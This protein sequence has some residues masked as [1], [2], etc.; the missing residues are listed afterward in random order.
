MYYID[1]LISEKSATQNTLESYRSNLHQFE[2]FLLKNGTTL[3]DASKVNIKDYVKFLYTQK[4]YKSSFIP[5]KISAAM[6]NFY[7][8]LFNDGIIDFN[9]APA[10]DDELKNPKISRPLPKYLSVNEILF[11]TETANINK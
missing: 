4:K 6:K 10:N 9:P 7:R 8:C 5:R 11:L 1:A 2:D 3:V